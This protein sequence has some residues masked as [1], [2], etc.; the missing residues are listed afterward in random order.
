MGFSQVGAAA[1]IATAL[2]MSVYQATAAALDA[3]HLLQEA[4]GTALRLDER[5]LHAAATVVSVTSA[6]GAVDIV[7]ENSGSATLDAA[8]V[9]VLLGGVP[10]T[11]TLREVE[12]AA[13]S[14]WPPL[15]DLHLQLTAAPPTDVVVVTGAG[16]LAFWRL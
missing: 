16:P 3:G 1:I 8:A 9:D 5:A 7:V 6:D 15:T 4:R 12:G 14:V 13:T 11:V 2:A 10:A